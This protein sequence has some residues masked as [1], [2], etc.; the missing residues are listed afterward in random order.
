[1]STPSPLTDVQAQILKVM[2]RQGAT[3]AAEIQQVTGLSL[4]VIRKEL[5][6]L[7]GLLFTHGEKTW[8]EALTAYE[9]MRAAQQGAEFVESCS[10]TPVLRDLNLG[11]ASIGKI[12]NRPSVMLEACTST[13]PSCVNAAWR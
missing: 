12:L 11:R 2:V 1:M 5:T 8:D 13:F 10:E 9:V 3:H 7:T 6:P 4:E